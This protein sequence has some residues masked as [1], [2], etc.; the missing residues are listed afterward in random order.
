MSVKRDYYEVLGVPR[1]ASGEQIKKAFRKLAFQYHP[2]HNKH[3][4][5]EEKFKEVSEAYKILSDSEKRANYDRYGHTGASDWTDFE[6]FGF[7]G[8]GDIFNAFFG[9][10]A[11]TAQRR[12]PRKGADLQANLNL[13]F[14]EAVFGTEKEIEIWRVEYCSLCH[15]TG[16]QPGTNPQRCPDCNG[17]GQVRRVQQSLF[18]RFVQTVVCPLC[19][20]EGTVITNRCLRCKGKGKEKVER[21]LNV[22]VPA[23]VDENYRM[24]LS[25]DGEAGKYGGPPGDIYIAFSIKAHGFFRRKG[26]DIYY[27]LPVNFTQAALGAEIELPTLDGRTMLKIPP[28][29][30]HGKTFRIKN[31]GVP[32]LNGNGR[33]D[34]L[35]TT[36]VVTPQTLDAN[37]VRLLEELAR[38][39]PLPKMPEDEDKGILGRIKGLFGED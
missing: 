31:K 17:S 35:V 18:G 1:N 24:R 14:E 21:K 34:H 22:I 23:G 12:S 39:L 32:H 20:G 9:G 2:D 38:T 7:G 4:E 25:G 10:A 8:L 16:S 36:R 28:G 33:G 27:D 29:T 6:G 19:Q 11:T 37:Q 5:A 15:G 26:D 3:A 13:S 30:Q